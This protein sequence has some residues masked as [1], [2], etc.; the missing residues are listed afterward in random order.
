MTLNHEVMGSNPALVLIILY[1]DWARTELGLLGIRS[2]SDES[3]RTPIGLVGECKVLF[4]SGMYF[5]PLFFFFIVI[6]MIIYSRLHVQQQ[7]QQHNAHLHTHQH[8][9]MPTRACLHQWRG[10]WRCDRL[11][12][13]PNEDLPPFC[14]GMY[15]IPFFF[16][17]YCY[18]NDYLQ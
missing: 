15:F 9:F 11:W 6:L 18:S 8:P 1:S 10:A 14:S 13:G 5:I 16:L 7:Q 2:E 4:C 17:F 3:D 12:K